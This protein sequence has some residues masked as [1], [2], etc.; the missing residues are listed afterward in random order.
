M[1]IKIYNV[2][3]GEIVSRHTADSNAECEAWADD[4]GYDTDQYGWTYCNEIRP[5]YVDVANE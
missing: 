2:D 5:G 1:E 4:Q 3:T